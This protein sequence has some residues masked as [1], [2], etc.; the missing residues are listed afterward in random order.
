MKAKSA[1]KIL[2]AVGVTV[3]QSTLHS[4]SKYTCKLQTK[5]PTTKLNLK[6]SRTNQSTIKRLNTK[7][8]MV[9]VIT[10]ILTMW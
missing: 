1:C 10:M 7:P 9:N 5:H 3:L 8:E 2:F 6:M 4:G